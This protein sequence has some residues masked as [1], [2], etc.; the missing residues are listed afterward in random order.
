MKRMPNSARKHIRQEKS[1]IRRRFSDKK[2][3]KQLIQELYFKFKKNENRRDI[4][5]SQ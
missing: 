1:R 5:I 3:Q 4:P 2:K